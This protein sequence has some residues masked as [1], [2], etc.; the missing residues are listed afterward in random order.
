[1]TYFKF[2]STEFSKSHFGQVTFQV[3]ASHLWLV[4]A[5]VGNTGGEMTH[6][7]ERFLELGSSAYKSWFNH[8]PPMGL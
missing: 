8:F 4:A 3:P 5:L 6:E 1:M 7:S 2:L